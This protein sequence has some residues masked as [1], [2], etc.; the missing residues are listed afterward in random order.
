MLFP[1]QYVLKIS[2][3]RP[4]GERHC[5]VFAVFLAMYFFGPSSPLYLGNQSARNPGLKVPDGRLNL[6]A[7]RE[8]TPAVRPMIAAPDASQ[9]VCGEHTGLL[10][11]RTDS[12]CETAGPKTWQEQDGL[13]VLPI[14]QPQRPRLDPRTQRS[15]PATPAA[16]PHGPS[17]PQQA[18]PQGLCLYIPASEALLSE[19]VPAAPAPSPAVTLCLA[20][21]HTGS[22]LVGPSHTPST[23][24]SP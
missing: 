17:A 20:P 2:T 4:S 1:A 10:M 6:A 14:S 8:F 16:P 22:L 12:P 23:R 15:A 9:G 11:L 21:A 3:Q 5:G 7:K 24:P 19:V 13:E 18:P